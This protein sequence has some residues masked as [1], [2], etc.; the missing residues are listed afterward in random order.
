MRDTPSGNEASAE[1]SGEQTASLH[2][3]LACI[4]SR[5][6][7]VDS[8]SSRNSPSSGDLAGWRERISSKS[9]VSSRCRSM[10]PITYCSPLTIVPRGYNTTKYRARRSHTLGSESTLCNARSQSCLALVGYSVQL[11]NEKCGRMCGNKR[12]KEPGRKG[13]S[14]VLVTLV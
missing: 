5:S 7:L 10:R 8:R 13:L 11:A 6:V 2:C 14:G 12:K 3:L 4:S 1:A 9:C